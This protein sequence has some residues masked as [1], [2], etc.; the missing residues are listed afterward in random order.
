MTNNKTK[1]IV[2]KNVTYVKYMT[3]NS[4]TG[5]REKIEYIVVIFLLHAKNGILLLFESNYVK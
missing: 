5:R 1:K 3:N 2:K 4:I